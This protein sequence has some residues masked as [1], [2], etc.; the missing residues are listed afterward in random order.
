MTRAAVVLYASLG[1][2]VLHAQEPAQTFDVVSVKPNVS[3]ETR[4]GTNSQPGL[5]DATNVT[6]RALILRAFDKQEFEVV[7]GPDW[8]ATDRFD[9]VGR[10][11]LS[12]DRGAQLQ[13]ALAD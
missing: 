3:G 4:S 11:P 7:G 13:A 6:L 12:A 8:V 9:F 10:G 5:L 1:L 2:M